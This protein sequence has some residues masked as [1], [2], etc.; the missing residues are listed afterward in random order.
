MP[1]CAYA[2]GFSSRSRL[3]VSYAVTSTTI[4]T[5]SGPAHSPWPAKEP[6]TA[7][8]PSGLAWPLR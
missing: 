6:F 2:L 7:R 5:W 4:S 3:S 1:V 8:V